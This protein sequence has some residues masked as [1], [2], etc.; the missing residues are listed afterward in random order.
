VKGVD[1]SLINK[2]ILQGIKCI[3]NPI[4]IKSIS[5]FKFRDKNKNNELSV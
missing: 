3:N 5:R 1:T 4:E 2:E